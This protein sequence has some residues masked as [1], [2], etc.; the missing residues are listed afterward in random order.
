MNFSRNMVDFRPFP[1]AL[2]KS[3]YNTFD[4]ISLRLLSFKPSSMSFK[5]VSGTPHAFTYM[6]VDSGIA[7]L[8]LYLSCA[9]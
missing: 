7:I 6:L 2:G 4:Y 3:L 8:V 1:K 9:L 5:L